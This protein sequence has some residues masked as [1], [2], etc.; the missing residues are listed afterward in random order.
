VKE[1]HMT[2]S[3]WINPMVFDWYPESQGH[4]SND[5]DFKSYELWN[6]AKNIIEKGEND[7]FLIDGICAL[8]RAV[9]HRLKYIT[10]TYNFNDIPLQGIPKKPLQ[11]LSYFGIIRPLMLKKLILIRNNIEHEYAS[12]PDKEFCMELLDFVWYFLKTTDYFT[13]LIPNNIVLAA[14]RFD[15]NSYYLSYTIDSENGWNI[16]YLQGKLPE[17]LCA[18]KKVDNWIEVVLIDEIRYYYDGG[19]ISFYKEKCI[20]AKDFN[21]FAYKTYF[22]VKI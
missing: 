22:K 3:V 10:D 6:H 17:E 15:D 8:K 20:F 5:P 7:F 18:F 21:T 12:P 19:I 9:S 14:K 16:S 4:F 13:E 1:N 2:S 11:Q